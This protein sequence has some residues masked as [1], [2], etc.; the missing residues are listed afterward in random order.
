[1]NRLPPFPLGSDKGESGS[2]IGP[3]AAA[4]SGDFLRLLRDS[5]YRL[6]AEQVA[7]VAA[8]GAALDTQGT[9]VIAMKYQGGVLN[10]ADRRATSENVVMYDRAE[11]IIPLDDHTLIAISGS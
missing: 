3:S 6:G 9:T 10:L 1:M 5:G 2:P 11:K 4:S 8:K 7:G